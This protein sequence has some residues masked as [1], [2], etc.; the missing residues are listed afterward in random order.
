MKERARRARIALSSFSCYTSLNHKDASHK[1][2]THGHTKHT[3]AHASQRIQRTVL[4]LPNL[5]SGWAEEFFI[6]LPCLLFLTLSLYLTL[7]FRVCKPH[8]LH[9]FPL[10]I[11]PPSTKVVLTYISSFLFYIHLKKEEENGKK[12]NH[13]WHTA[14]KHSRIHAKMYAFVTFIRSACVCAHNYAPLC[15]MCA[16]PWRRAQRLD[17]QFFQRA[18]LSA[19]L[20]SK[21]FFIHVS[22]SASASACMCVW[23]RISFTQ[24]S[25]TCPARMVLHDTCVHHSCVFVFVCTWNVCKLKT[26][27]FYFYK[28]IHNKLYVFPFLYVPP[29]FIY[30]LFCLIDALTFYYII[31]DHIICI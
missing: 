3:H 9:C 29:K 2:Q 4:L 18:A 26:V 24:K 23:S 6:R 17:E 10:I 11:I 16:R 5:W 7:T 25:Y 20:R 31:M 27:L 14:Q 30:N 21:A 15:Q 8:F 19:S 28:Y 1:L 13:R 12:W 22:V